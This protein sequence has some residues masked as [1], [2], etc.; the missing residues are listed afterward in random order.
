LTSLKGRAEPKRRFHVQAGARGTGLRL[1]EKNNEI[2]NL[3][4]TKKFSGRFLKIVLAC[5]NRWP[6]GAKSD[7]VRAS[8]DVRRA[9]HFHVAQRRMW[10]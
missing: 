1:N 9:A 6:P 5:P 4:A 10:L 2:N 3:S 8:A 7:P